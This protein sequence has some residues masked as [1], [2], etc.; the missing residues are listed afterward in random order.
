MNEEDIDPVNAFYFSVRFYGNFLFLEQPNDILDAEVLGKSV[1]LI[2][3]ELTNMVNLG[4]EH[5]SERDYLSV[6]SIL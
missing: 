6:L 5:L 4:L 3:K 1:K 2:R